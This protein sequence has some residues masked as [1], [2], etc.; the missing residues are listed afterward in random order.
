M[1]QTTRLECSQQAGLEFLDS[2]VLKSDS[3]YR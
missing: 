3:P 1:S 2:F